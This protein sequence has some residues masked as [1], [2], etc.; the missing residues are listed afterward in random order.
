MHRLIKERKSRERELPRRVLENKSQKR[1]KEVVKQLLEIGQ[2]TAGYGLERVTESGH[3]KEEPQTKLHLTYNCSV[4]VSGGFKHRTKNEVDGCRCRCRT[5][6]V[7]RERQVQTQAEINKLSDDA[8]KESKV[9]RVEVQSRGV[10]ATFEWDRRRVRFLNSETE[11]V[12]RTP[13]RD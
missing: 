4:H 12:G 13:S 7:Q 10:R 9:S 8:D 5:N 3:V 2:V 6:C 11:V 1:R